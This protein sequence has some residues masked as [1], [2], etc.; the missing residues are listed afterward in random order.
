MTIGE[1]IRKLRKEKGWTQAELAFEA[2]TNSL[3]IS[4]YENG[5]ALPS[6]LNLISIAD[7]LGVTLDELVGRTKIKRK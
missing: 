7:A 2:D 1:N 5:R 3:S 4:Y 6:I